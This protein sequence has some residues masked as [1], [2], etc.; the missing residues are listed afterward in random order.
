MSN[1][2][3]TVQQTDMA[4][5]NSVIHK[6]QQSKSEIWNGDTQRWEKVDADIVIMNYIGAKRPNSTFFYHFKIL[7]FKCVCVRESVHTSLCLGC[8]RAEVTGNC[9]LPTWVLV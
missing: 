7:S 3:L 5:L 4:K 1:S 2:K 6:I 8:P 9:E